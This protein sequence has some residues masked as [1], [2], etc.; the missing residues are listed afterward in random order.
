MELSFF[1]IEPSQVHLT[2]HLTLLS[3][4]CQL[5]KVKIGENRENSHGVVAQFG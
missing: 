2:V 5:S 4:R 3:E 1:Y